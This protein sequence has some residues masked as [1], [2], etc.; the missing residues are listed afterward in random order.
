MTLRTAALAAPL[1]AALVLAGCAGAPKLTPWRADALLAA[2]PAACTP[3]GAPPAAA[4]TPVIPGGLTVVRSGGRDVLLVA[5]RGCVMTVDAATGA[6]ELLPTHGDSIAPTMVHATSGGVAFTSSLSRSVR[7]I[8]AAGAVTFNVSGLDMPLGVQLL[9]GGAALVAEFTRGRVLRV[10]P[11]TE[12]RPRLVA[13]ALEGPVGIAVVDATRAYVTEYL[14]GRVTEIRLDRFEKRVVA[15]GLSRPE[16][17][18]VLPDGRIAVAETGLRRLVAIEP[19]KGRLEVMADNLPIGLDSGQ[20]VNDPYSV[21]DVA[22]GPDGTLYVSSD[23]DGTVLRV[24]P[25][26]R[27]QK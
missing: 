25:R 27:P 21:T 19:A 3:A 20:G 2:L 4:P 17:L 6:T 9:P 22:A 7:A 14:P 24:T 16:G 5:A 11:T 1:A 23:M 26:P 12:S 8:D 15:K 18:A 13:E 10:G